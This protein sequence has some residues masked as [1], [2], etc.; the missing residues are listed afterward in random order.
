M[1]KVQINLIKGDKVSS[2]T[3][4]LDA[5][6][7]NMLAI[8]RPML[9]AAGYML[10]HPGLKEYGTGVGPDRGG[11]WNERLEGHYRVSGSQFL[12]V[13]ANGSNDRFGTI[14]GLEQVSMP[15]SFNTQAIIGGG[16][17]YL[18]DKTN[19]FR[20]VTD[21]DVK[22]PID[23]TWIDGYYFLTDGDY[24]YHT[25][26]NDESSFS[27]LTFATSEFSPDPT[28]GVGKTA[29][30]KVIVFNR[31]TTEFFANVASTNFA[32]SRI[33]SRALKIGIVAT[34]AKCELNQNWYFLGG[35][36]E[37]AIG[38]HVLGVGS[39][40]QIS[41][42]SID[43]IIGQYTEQQLVDAS[44]ESRIQ[45]G[46]SVVYV[47]LPNEC[48][49]FNE[50]I[51][52]SNGIDNAWSIIKRG[53]NNLPWRGINGIFEPRL[54][55]WV[56]G[57]KDDL[58]IGILDESVTTQYGEM[59]EWVLYTPFMQLEEL[60]IDSLTVE[61]IPG[62]TG[63]DDATVFVSITYDGVTYGKEFTEAY[64]AP[65]DYNKRYIVNRLGFVRNWAGFKLRGVSLSRMAFGSGVIE[66]G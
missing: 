42:R 48:L 20:Q 61:T 60:S 7:E 50:T 41:S 21:P 54:G 35:R 38:V 15:Y 47:H 39:S 53:V 57:D 18:Y 44:M 64:G 37:G 10:Q 40:Q 58:R 36:K 30:D 43:K 32:F 34:H 11:V 28:K 13:N 27:P 6:P 63:S 4:Y 14:P 45:D 49:M 16:G 52:Q 51:A 62:H 26:L 56:Y 29:D 25:N 5:L 17:F 9:G 66:V 59:A 33:Q 19:G 46:M 12:V 22:T 1:P 8:A 55:V 31:Y 2:K 3:D 24:L 65:S 23:G